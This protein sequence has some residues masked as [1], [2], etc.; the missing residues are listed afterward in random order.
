MSRRTALETLYGYAAPPEGLTVEQRLVWLALRW[1]H[2]QAFAEALTGRA[3]HTWPNEPFLWG[4]LSDWCLSEA[5]GLPWSDVLEAAIPLVERGIIER[6]DADEE[7]SRWRV[8]LTPSQK[9]R[10]GAEAF[11]QA[12]AD[13]GEVPRV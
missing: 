1:V 2:D 6:R 3:H 11:R 8:V 9:K 10:W 7:V 5:T 13:T 12:W 4:W